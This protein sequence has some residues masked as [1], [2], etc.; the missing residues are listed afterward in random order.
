MYQVKGYA[1]Q[2]AKTALAPYN[3]ERREVG[4]TDI[5][6][7]ILYCGVCHSDL[8][9]ARDEWAAS[10]FPIVPGH[11]IVGR[12]TQVGSDVK[13]FKVNDLAG[14]GCMVDSCGVC[15]DCN[16]HQE[17]FCN[18]FVLTYNGHDKHTGK[19]TYGGFSNSIVVD[20]R[21]VLHIS[22]KLELAAVAPLLCAGITTYSPLR[23]WKIG[24][25][26]KVGVVGLGGLGHM[27][28]KFAHAFG[29]HVVLFT[30]SAGKAEDAKRLGADEVVISK[31]PD[32][33][34]AHALSFDFILNTVAA[35][36]NL[37]QFM[38]LL[39]RDGTMCLVGV[40]D[41]PH[42]SP[43]IANLIFKRRSLAGSLIG[44]IKETQEML[45]FCAEHNITSDIE[46][47]PMS[48]INNA[49]ERML[50]SDVRYR[51]VIDMATI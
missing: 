27:A 10:T 30:T 16:D 24:K 21:F 8:H 38:S 23:H 47:I 3:F 35:P 46:I 37:D 50:K 18:D 9:Q 5:K 44:G 39:K 14:V 42:P 41:S 33:M 29:A 28:V 43:N 15:P 17:Q 11:E 4:P 19:P 25:G 12:V 6:I 22:D 31:N 20:Q 7:E 40:P 45:D 48:G 13:S 36:H 51:F 32:E 49:F 1:A 2:N 34:N 26:D